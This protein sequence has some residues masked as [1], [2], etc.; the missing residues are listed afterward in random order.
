MAVPPFNVNDLLVKPVYDVAF[1]GEDITIPL[2]EDTLAL[3]SITWSTISQLL[4]LAPPNADAHIEDNPR[5]V[6]DIDTLGILNEGDGIQYDRTF[7]WLSDMS[8]WVYKFHI[9]IA[10]ALSVTAFTSGSHNVD[11]IRVIITERLQDGTLVKPVADITEMTGMTAL[12]AT[13]VNVVVATLEG[14]KPFKISQGNIVRIQI[15]G[16]RTDTGVA[17]S[18]EGIMPLFYTQE[19]ALAKLLQESN[20]TLHVHPALDHAFEVFRD[21]S[22]QEQ[23]DYDGVAK[24]RNDRSHSPLGV[25]Y[26]RNNSCTRFVPFLLGYHSLYYTCSF[27]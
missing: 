12:T 24:D 22:F 26:G 4:Q 1:Y 15:I 13:G 18:F 10:F 11:S 8:A 16:N 3:A 9:S 6:S 19:G 21:Q 14:N 5:L 27:I 7:E 17:T 2:S 25:L 23:L 20:I